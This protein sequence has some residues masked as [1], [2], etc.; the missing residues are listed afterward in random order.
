VALERAEQAGGR[1]REQLDLAVVGAA[2]DQAAAGRDAHGA[3][4]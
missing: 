1:E 4:T 3:N 2:G